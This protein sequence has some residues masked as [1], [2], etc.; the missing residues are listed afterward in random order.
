MRKRHARQ[1][2]LD[3][4]AA[5]VP[6]VGPAV[7]QELFRLLV[8]TVKDYAISLLDPQGRI[9]SWNAGAERLTGYRADE[10]V[11]KPISILY[12]PE[13]IAQGKPEQD[14]QTAATRER[15]QTEG[16]RV[17]KD[18][19]RYSINLTVTALRDHAGHLIGF[20]RIAHDLTTQRRE[21]EALRTSEKHFRLLA[22]NAQDVI[23]E[24]RL[25]PTVA[26]DYVSPAATKV[27]GYTPQDYYADP[28][29]P[30]KTVLP[31]DRPLLEDILT[32]PT[33]YNGQTITFRFWRKDGALIWV[34]RTATL[35]YDQTGQVVAIQ[36][37]VRDVTER[38]Q[39]EDERERLI[40][41]LALERSRLQTVI[42]R[43]PAGI[44]LFEAPLGERVIANPRAEELFGRRIQPE[45]GVSQYAGQLF[46]PDGR[47]VAP[48]E[49]VSTRALQEDVVVV[50]EA[51]IRQ[52]TGREVTVQSSAAPIRDSEG[53]LIGA[54]IIFEDI[55]PI[56]EL[57][58]AREEWTSVIAHDLRQPVTVIDGYAKLLARDAEK[59]P[60]EVHV[61]VRHI[62]ASATQIDRMIADLLDVSRIEAHRLTLDCRQVDFPTLV[63]AV[64]ERTAMVTKGH[65]VCVTIAGEI[66]QLALDPE[67]IEQVLSNLLSNAAKYSFPDTE[68]LVD[69]ERRNA[70]VEVAVTNQG[71]GIAPKE[72]P[73]LFQRYYRTR[74]ARAGRVGG[75]GLGLY[76]SKGLVEAH[77]GRIWAESIP[78]RT[79]TFRFTLPVR[80]KA[81]N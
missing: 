37:I 11:G 81:H 78:G 70:A 29:L 64:I 34:E 31:A 57:E 65:E 1:R 36:G 33:K 71:P 42:A 2:D 38:R 6:G 22:E 12:L 32:N 55:S 40:E 17:R 60:P 77:G 52:P 75:V 19:S 41:Q 72:L 53:T 66:P 44:I 59:Y 9:I 46:H 16:W 8:E 43:A 47:P 21:E 49:F 10:V 58:R 35:V 3:V 45:G 69:V 13:E 26:H 51:I 27:F 4:D 23:F 28:D 20:A 15:F 73:K 18:G 79:T 24:T 63:R 62:L 61:W 7:T 25:K 56:R 80:E 67:R 76:I 54:V 50:D 30:L 48:E 68:V 74:E 5:G 14:L 39:A